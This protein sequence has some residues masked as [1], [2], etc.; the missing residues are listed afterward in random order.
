MIGHASWAC[1][2]GYAS[3]IVI[4]VLQAAGSDCQGI[5]LV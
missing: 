5:C 3:V 2:I 1:L 4:Y